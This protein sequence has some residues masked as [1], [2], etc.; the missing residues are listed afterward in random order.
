MGRRSCSGTRAC[1]TGGRGR[2]RA[3]SGALLQGW[4]P[5]RSVVTGA[6]EGLARSVVPGAPEGPA[7]SVVTGAPEGPARSVVPGAPEG[8]ARPAVPGAPEGPARPAVPGAPEGPTTR[9]H[10]GQH[11]ATTWC[12]MGEAI[13]RS[14]PGCCLRSLRCPRIPWGSGTSGG[15]VGAAGATKESE[16]GP[17]AISTQPAAAARHAKHVPR[18]VPATDASA[19]A[20]DAGH[21]GCATPPC[22]PDSACRSIGPGS[23]CRGAVAVQAVGPAPDHQHHSNGGAGG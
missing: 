14:V 21:D 9:E 12:T 18:H 2:G 7:R 22:V 10:M 17:N 16:A 4:H 15:V 13:P 23:S 19:A 3:S 1:L 6:P 11:A 8:P 5:T 20:H